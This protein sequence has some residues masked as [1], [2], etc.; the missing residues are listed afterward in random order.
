MKI[1][2]VLN[3]KAKIRVEEYFNVYNRVLNNL[4]YSK[5]LMMNEYSR[6]TLIPGG[7]Y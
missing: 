3:K 6:N 4:L 5:Y 2:A 1:G 7:F